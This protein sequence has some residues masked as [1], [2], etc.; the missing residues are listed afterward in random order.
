M[1][2]TASSADGDQLW[3]SARTLKFMGYRQFTVTQLDV[4]S[5]Y[6]GIN[7]GKRWGEGRPSRDR[8]KHSL[9]IC[10]KPISHR[11]WSHS[12]ACPLESIGL[13][14]TKHYLQWHSSEPITVCVAVYICGLDAQNDNKRKQWDCYSDSVPTVP[15][16]LLY[17]WQHITL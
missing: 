16:Q 15:Y 13:H 11:I 17:L 2:S 4:L 3:P 1:K 7:N 8:N 5:L 10:C 12:Y 14:H 9:E 6:F